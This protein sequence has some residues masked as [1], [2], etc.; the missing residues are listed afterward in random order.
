VFQTVCH[1]DKVTL[2]LPSQAVRAHLEN[3]GD[4]LG[5]C[6]DNISTSQEKSK[7]QAKKL[8]LEAD[9]AQKESILEAKN[10]QNNSKKDNKE[11]KLPTPG[12][13]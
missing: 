10:N 1:N 8:Q 3:H 2:H 9:K 13:K 11:S 12:P 5:E 7:H 6:S 4:I